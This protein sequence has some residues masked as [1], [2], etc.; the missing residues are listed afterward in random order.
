M[1]G[2]ARASESIILQF[3]EWVCSLFYMQEKISVD[4]SM[5]VMVLSGDTEC[6]LLWICPVLAAA[7]Q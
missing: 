1:G 7:A 2:G 6:L 3:H 4:T 5:D